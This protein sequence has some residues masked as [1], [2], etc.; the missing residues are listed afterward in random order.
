MLFNSYVFIFAFLPAVLLGFF[1]IARL[2]KNAALLWLFGASLFFYGWWNHAFVLLI[3]ASIVVNYAFFRW[4]TH[5]RDS[6]PAN[7]KWVLTA[8]IVYNLGVLGYYKYADFFI[9]NVNN[10]TNSLFLLQHVIVPIGL[11]FYI[12]MQIACLVDS[13]RGEIKGGSFLEYCIFVSFFPQLTAGPIV[14]YQEIIPQFKK[15]ENYRLRFTNL[16][17]GLTIFF[18][19]LFKK[20]ILAD[21][22]AVY[23][24]VVFEAA[25]KGVS[26]TS[27]EAW[28]GALAYTFQLYFDFSGY[29]DM[30]IGLARMF[31]IV[32][33][34]NFFSPYKAKNIIE[35]WRCW[36]VTLSR[37]LRDY[38]YIP[39]GGNRKSTLRRY[40]NVMITMLLA[41]LWHGAGW[42]FVF[43]GGLHG[44]YLIIN[45][46]WHK[47]ADRVA[48]RVPERWQWLT[49]FCA[50][51]LTFI[52]VVFAWV[53]F[54]AKSFSDAM[55]IFKGM[56]ND[57]V[58]LPMFLIDKIVKPGGII[59]EAFPNIIPSL[60]PNWFY[61]AFLVVIITVLVVWFLPNTSEL[62][63]DFKPV[64]HPLSIRRGAFLQ[65]LR[66]KPNL[67]WFAFILLAAVFCLND[68][69]N[70]REFLYY[71]F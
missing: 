61:Y 20:V 6:R 50:R 7:A 45:Q 53:P 8:G 18:I 41:G 47:I 37:F 43:W 52:A 19:G 13:Y 62:M 71:Q 1:L 10:V 35:F 70:V 58:N 14:R 33:P 27:H 3:L 24:N 59:E 4:L 28:L 11:S 54:R 25:G 69:D 39:L 46:A 65:R 57:L 34:L 44:G 40:I 16:S 55:V 17:V 23:A 29:A 5:P 68:L 60:P 9:G 48:F 66:W 51:A 30:A 32:L 63:S 38:L 67:Y 31:N 22:I 64:L 42:T 21:H 49:G 36:H 2:N 26:L 12:F 15:T 56:T